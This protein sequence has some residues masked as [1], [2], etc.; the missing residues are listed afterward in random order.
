MRILKSPKRDKEKLK[1]AAALPPPMFNYHKDDS[2]L[3]KGNKS[4]HHDDM[5][6]IGHNS[7]NALPSSQQRRASAGHI[8]VRGQ[9]RS[10]QSPARIKKALSTRQQRVTTTGSLQSNHNSASSAIGAQ[11]LDMPD[12]NAASGGD[13]A[14]ANN[15]GGSGMAKFVIPPFKGE[16]D[17]AGEGNAGD[18]KPK[19]DASLSVSSLLGKNSSD[20]VAASQPAKKT[21]VAIGGVGV[22][23]AA[24]AAAAAGLSGGSDDSYLEEEVVESEDDVLEEEF[25]E[26]DDEYIVE[27]FVEDELPPR[28]IT[29]RFDE[30]DEMTTVLHLND[31]TKSEMNK[32]WYV[33]G[34][35]DRMVMESRKIAEKVEER[36]KEG[37]GRDA[38]NHKRQVEARGLEA[39]TTQGATRAKLIKAA[40]VDAVWNEQSRQWDEGIT[41]ADSIREAYIAIS[42]DSI[43]AA[44]ARA[45]QDYIQVQKIKQEDEHKA[46][47]KRRENILAKSKHALGK[48]VKVTGSLAKKTGI[49]VGKTTLKTGKVVGKTTLK[50]AGFAVKASVATATLDSKALMKSIRD[51]TKDK[52][53]DKDK[54]ADNA[55]QVY[56][57]PSLSSQFVLDGTYFICSSLLVM[58]FK[59]DVP[60]SYIIAVFCSFY[61]G[62]LRHV[63][64]Q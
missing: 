22:G 57:R 6:A 43:A 52:K 44:Q 28:K 30:F 61:V 24:A 25:V 47:M 38:K 46:E 23:A 18:D 10:L 31:Y 4:Q 64:R 27:E 39:W 48:S 16:N 60:C 42:K 51:V 32:A 37:T 34:D 50:T 62:S 36:E 21:K 17:A 41:D 13:M 7:F 26:E 35:Y 45:F 9:G 56:K 8:T 58:R 40:A 29:I 2:E 20:H 53:K 11:F 15:S 5:M 54:E 33:R 55:G 49:V 59:A 63:I 14:S 12:F 3:R 1:L 19:S